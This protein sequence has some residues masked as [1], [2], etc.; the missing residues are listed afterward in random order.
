MNYGVKEWTLAQTETRIGGRR[1]ISTRILGR[2]TAPFH[3]SLFLAAS[4]MVLPKILV[5]TRAHHRHCQVDPKTQGMLEVWA[6]SALLA[7]RVEVQLRRTCK[8][9]FKGLA[10]QL[11]WHCT[12]STCPE[13]AQATRVLKALGIDKRHG[14]RYPSAAARQALVP[15]SNSTQFLGT[16]RSLGVLLGSD[17]GVKSL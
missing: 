16:C 11:T 12:P 17:M 1:R 13:R 4:R 5:L 3:H 6:D 7:D 10:M 15:S 14:L 8:R 9:H 2:R